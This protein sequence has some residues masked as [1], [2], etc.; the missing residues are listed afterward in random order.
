MGD[1]ICI[2]ESKSGNHREFPILPSLKRLFISIGERRSG[3][4]F[5][6]TAEQCDYSFE[7]ALKL[8]KIENF[9]YHDFC[10][11]FA[12]AYRMVDGNLGNLQALLGHADLRMT[13]RYAHLS[14]DYIAQAIQC[15][16]GNPLLPKVDSGN[17]ANVQNI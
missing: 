6:L 4:V 13:N 8:A 2:L 14:P 7:K 10:H 3:P 17:M 1:T 15:M 12:S 16:N 11:T 9:R 5:N